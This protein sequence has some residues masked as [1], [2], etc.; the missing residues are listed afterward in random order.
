MRAYVN[1]KVISGKP[2]L[3]NLI[4]N[5][6]LHKSEE[7]GWLLLLNPVR[8]LTPSKAMVI[9]SQITHVYVYVCACLCPHVKRCTASDLSL[10]LRTS[11]WLPPGSRLLVQPTQLLSWML[12]IHLITSLIRTQPYLF[13]YTAD[14]TLYSWTLHLQPASTAG[15]Y[16]LFSRIFYS[17]FCWI[18]YHTQKLYLHLNPF[19][20]L[21]QFLR[22]WKFLE[23]YYTSLFILTA[24]Q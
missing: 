18:S 2:G 21:S 24:I 5:T 9:A 7:K 15:S 12:F 16:S 11:S 10:V 6:S 22:P 14:S 3:K 4:R 8:R 1:M 20:P 19:K 17:L 13:A 23:L